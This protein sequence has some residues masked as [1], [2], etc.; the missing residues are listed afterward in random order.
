VVIS[1][2]EDEEEEETNSHNDLLADFVARMRR[3]RELA[4]SDNQ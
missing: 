2:D 1:D 4:L 3:N